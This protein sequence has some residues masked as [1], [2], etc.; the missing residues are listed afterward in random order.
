MSVLF[1]VFL[2]LLQGLTEFL[3]VSSSGHLSILQNFFGMSDIEHSHMLFDVLLHLGTLISVLIV[4]RKDIAA[5]LRELFL[6]CAEALGLKKRESYI[7]LEDETRK[8]GPS[9]RL[10]LLILVATLPLIAVLPVKDLVEKLYYKTWF[11]GLAL[12]ITGCLL[13]ISDRV[14]AGKK[15]ERNATLGNALAIGCFQALAVIPGL[16]RSGSTISA[17]I[18]SGCRREF[19]VKFSFLLSVPAV[20]GANI[21]SIADAAKAG[22]DVS[23]LPAYLAGMAAAAVS[24]CAAIKLVGMLAARGKFGGFAYYCWAVGL[25]TIIA[26]F[27]V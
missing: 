23:L 17:G 10:M 11:I 19:A 20:L 27:I 5:M 4:Y 18:F 15:N 2:G 26:A 22:V 12:L 9:R 8:G 14:V 1:A 16:S 13:Y 21:L 3:P 24:G 25:V 6:L 7:G